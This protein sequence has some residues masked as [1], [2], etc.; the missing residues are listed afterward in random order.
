MK[1]ILSLVLAIGLVSVPIVAESPSVDL[2]AMTLDELVKLR[3]RVN[4][5][6]DLRVSGTDSTIG[7]GKYVV[8]DMIAG[9]IYEFI[10]TEVEYMSGNSY[11]KLHVTNP[12]TD[13]E[14][15]SAE[16]IPMGTPVIFSLHDG[17]VLE[18]SG[19]SGILKKADKTWILNE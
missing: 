5:E 7:R 18:I 13:E 4:L 10:P 14:I 19:G 16:Y 2:S 15:T 8:G 9:G 12:N 11:C 1:K 3:D 17:D 6:I